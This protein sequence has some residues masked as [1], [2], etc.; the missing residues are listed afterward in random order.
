MYGYT[1]NKR[2]H[3]EN[4]I[5]SFGVCSEHTR[6]GNFCHLATEYTTQGRDVFKN[7]RQRVALNYEHGWWFFFFTR[8]R[9]TYLLYFGNLRLNADEVL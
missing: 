6:T 1:N 5:W 4:N 2:R 9:F 3:T 7:I 8:R